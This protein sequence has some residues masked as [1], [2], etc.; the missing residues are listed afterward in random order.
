MSLKKF[1]VFF[2]RSNSRGI[3]L[4]FTDI[5]AAKLYH[6]FNLRKKVEEF[7]SQTKFKLNREILVRAIA[8]IIGTER[9]GPISIDKDFILEHLEAGDFQTHW[10][11]VCNLYNESLQYLVNQ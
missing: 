11:A 8:Y 5:L 6:G 2:E 10:D 1:C 4:N 9:K 3:Q 7:E